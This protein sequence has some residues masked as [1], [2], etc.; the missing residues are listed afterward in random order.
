MKLRKLIDHELLARRQQ[1]LTDQEF[2]ALLPHEN[3]SIET[4]A[5]MIVQLRRKSL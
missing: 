4:A 3:W 5:N 1:P 2:L